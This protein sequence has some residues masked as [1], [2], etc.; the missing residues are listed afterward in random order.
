MCV[1]VVVIE[2]S[3][4]GETRPAQDELHAVLRYKHFRMVRISVGRS[5]QNLFKTCQISQISWEKERAR[6]AN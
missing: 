1:C 6:I 2:N 4:N 3:R 5:T